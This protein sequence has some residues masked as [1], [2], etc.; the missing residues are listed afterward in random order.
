MRKREPRLF[1]PKPGI[2]DIMLALSTTLP[3]FELMSGR[4]VRESCPLFEVPVGA[5]SSS[6]RFNG[7]G[8]KESHGTVRSH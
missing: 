5:V 6:L 2:L 3:N 7:P 4:I 1:V 8:I